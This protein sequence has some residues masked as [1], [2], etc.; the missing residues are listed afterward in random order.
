MGCSQLMSEG[1]HILTV[2]LEDYFQ[3]LTFRKLISTQQWHRFETRLE[4]NTLWVLDLLDRH[5]V[6]A[7]FFVVGWTAERRPDLVREVVRRGHEVANKG[8]YLNSLD[9]VTRRELK[10]NLSRGRNAIEDATGTAVIGCRTPH[11]LFREQ[12]LW[13][14]DLLAEQG[15]HYDSSMVPALWS[16]PSQPWRRFIHQHQHKNKTLWEVPLSTYRIC[17]CNFPMSGGN[18]VRQLPEGI[19]GRL[20]KR[21]TEQYTSPLVM[22]FHVWEFDPGQVRIDGASTIAR[23]RHYRNLDKAARI[24]ENYLSRYSFTGIADY[25]GLTPGSVPASRRVP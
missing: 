14:L 15:Y 20:A 24:W 3:V 4:E 18:Y 21:W 13:V 7:T 25:L 1:Q 2:S 12:D 8:Y 19:V 17:G 11:F 23:I 5:Q 10:D 22:Y 16:F 9:G 6:R